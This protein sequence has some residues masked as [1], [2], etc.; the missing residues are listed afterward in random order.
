MKITFPNFPSRYGGLRRGTGFWLA[1]L[2]RTQS[3]FCLPATRRNV[4]LLVSL[5]RQVPPRFNLPDAREAV[6]ISSPG[7]IRFTVFPSTM[8]RF[9]DTRTSPRTA[10]SLASLVPTA[11][12]RQ[13][14]FMCGVCRSIRSR[15]SDGKTESRTSKTATV[16]QPALFKLE[17]WLTSIGPLFILPGLPTST[18]DASRTTPPKCIRTMRCSPVK[19]GK[20]C[21]VVLVCHGEWKPAHQF[22]RRPLHHS[23]IT[24][25]LIPVFGTR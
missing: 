9:P 21:L 7:L 2:I 24:Q 23:R 17:K 15:A 20:E 25:A 10:L 6:M 4:P 16:S 1:R 5:N 12:H 3:R 8:P 22:A 18:L 13:F 19:N 11:L 14:F